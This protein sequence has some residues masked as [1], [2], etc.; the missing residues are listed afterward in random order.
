MLQ[1]NNLFNILSSSIVNNP[2]Q[3]IFGRLFLSMVG[4]ITYS[5]YYNSSSSSVKNNVSIQTNSSLVNENIQTDSIP[6]TQTLV[7]SILE[8]PIIDTPVLEPNKLQRDI[9]FYNEQGIQ[10][11]NSNLF[12][13]LTGDSYQ[14]TQQNTISTYNLEELQAPMDHFIN[15]GGRR[16]DIQGYIQYLSSNNER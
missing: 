6:I 8:Y 7:D 4:F 12:Y 10:T 2:D 3:L 14:S 15:N 11:D 1:N 5:I 16:S 9:S 13:L